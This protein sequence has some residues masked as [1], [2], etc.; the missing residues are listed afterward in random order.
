M[1]STE[2]D[3]LDLL[4]HPGFKEWVHTPSEENNMYWDRWLKKYPE[5]KPMLMKA[6]EFVIRMQLKEEALHDEVQLT[7][8]EVDEILNSIIDH[9]QMTRPHRNFMIY[10][11]WKRIAAILALICTISL[12]IFYAQNRIE[13][14]PKVSLVTKTNPGH[15][16]SQFQLPDGT[17]V[18][19]NANSEISYPEKF[20]D[21]LRLITLSGEAYF[22][23]VRDKER[24]FKVN[25]E[26]VITTVL[27]TSFNISAYPETGKVR[28]ALV[29]GKVTVQRDAPNAQSF[30]IS[31]GEKIIFDQNIDYE[32]ISHFD[33]L[34]EVGWKDGILAFENAGFPEFLS[35]LEHWYGVE[36]LVQGKPEDTWQIEGRFD[37]ES[38]EEILKGVQFTHDLT[39][40]IN[41]KQVIIKF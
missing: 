35:R 41:E 39:Y 3:I 30:M 40:E 4:Q 13:N 2:K 18:H 28:V 22:D 6:R 16:R 17:R 34:L 27:G 14:E 24:P 20:S 15:E 5:K 36:F 33:E 25:A 31:P 19:L 10:G 12:L 21:S 7:D 11:Q 23:V 37:N 26:N 1:D 38:L 29:S 8:P 32:T 9:S